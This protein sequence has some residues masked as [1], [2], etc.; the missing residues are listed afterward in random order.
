MFKS[1]AYVAHALK[2]QS[3]PVLVRQIHA[4]LSCSYLHLEHT[5]VAFFEHM[6]HFSSWSWSGLFRHLRLVGVISGPCPPDLGS[7]PRPMSSRL[8]TIADT[9]RG[10]RENP[11][12]NY[13][14]ST[15][16]P[17]RNA[18]S[19]TEDM[20]CKVVVWKFV[21]FCDVAHHNWRVTSESIAQQRWPTTTP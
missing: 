16:L 13:C 8:A 7:Q 12:C 11:H 18:M 19:R 17:D 3:L 10:R 9:G 4:S 21:L 5:S 14:R 15:P 2:K 6:Q 20:A 1:Y